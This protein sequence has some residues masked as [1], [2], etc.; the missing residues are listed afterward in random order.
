[1]TTPA[2]APTGGQPPAQS[3]PLPPGASLANLGIPSFTGDP[4]LSYIEIRDFS[5]GIFHSPVTPVRQAVDGAAQL[6]GTYDCVAGLTGE[7]IP[8]PRRI[9]QYSKTQMTHTPSASPG[10]YP[11][12]MHSIRIEDARCASPVF[13]GSLESES[14]LPDVIFIGQTTYYNSSGAGP[15]AAYYD[16][17]NVERHA[18]HL[19]L[20]TAARTEY[21]NRET[22]SLNIPLTPSSV[23]LMSVTGGGQTI[24]EGNAVVSGHISLDIGRSN[25]V[26]TSVGFPIL[27]ALIYPRYTPASSVAFYTPDILNPA[28]NGTA[29]MEF[30]STSANLPYIVIAHQDRFLGFGYGSVGASS[31][32]FGTNTNVRAEVMRATNVNDATTSASIQSIFSNES[33]YGIGTWVSM[34]ASELLIIKQRGGGYVLRGDVAN[35]QI[36]RLPGIASANPMHRG[37]MTVQGFVYGNRRGVWIWP[38]GDTSVCISDQIEGFFWNPLIRDDAQPADSAALTIPRGGGKEQRRQFYGSFGFSYPYVYAP[39][40][41]IYD[42]RLGSWFRISQPGKYPYMHYCDSA[43]GN[44][45]A[46]PSD[47]DESNLNI[48]NWYAHDQGANSYQWKSQ[49]LH[50]TQS[51]ILNYREVVLFAQGAQAKVDITLEGIDGATETVTFEFDSPDRRV[52]LRQPISIETHDVVVTI[53]AK[54]KDLTKAAP[55]LTFALGYNTGSRV[56]QVK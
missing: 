10:Y 50:R 45:I 48:F 51:N 33:P 19:G 27:G 46:I 5:P 22:D 55:S 31:I 11:T 38:G 6:D 21:S 29:T 14:V 1:M 56:Q 20:D 42:M 28:G 36:V 40:N 26:A 44:M 4:G 23:T 34:N 3:S 7:L 8:G 13:F 39:N 12:Q 9:F 53:A 37:T 17:F 41:F 30:G 16:R 2:P 15:G 54:S 24:S 25:T 32:N 35:P 49:P 52:C 18:F 43:N 47:W